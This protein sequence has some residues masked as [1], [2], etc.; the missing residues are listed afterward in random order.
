MKLYRKGS[1][2]GL[3]FF[4][5]G[6]RREKPKRRLDADERG[7]SRIET[8]LQ[9]EY[10]FACLIRVQTPFPGSQPYQILMIVL[11]GIDMDHDIP[12]VQEVFEDEFFD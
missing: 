4:A 5:F 8:N 10:V 11:M 9:L 6:R 1:P 7:F 2:L 12:D 3:P